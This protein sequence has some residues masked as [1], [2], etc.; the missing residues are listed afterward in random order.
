MIATINLY[1]VLIGLSFGDENKR[2]ENRYS[3]VRLVYPL[4]PSLTYV[5]KAR[6]VLGPNFFVLQLF[7]NTASLFHLYRADGY[8]RCI[9]L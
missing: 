1:F 9:I 7:V 6:D 3:I 4:R 2:R 8:Y 5:H